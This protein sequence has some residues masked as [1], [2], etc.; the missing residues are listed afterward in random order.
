M[1]ATIAIARVVVLEA[2]RGRVVWLLAA[3]LASAV[4]LAEFMAQVA[5]T[6]SREVARGVL[7]A[8]LRLALVFVVALFVASSMA[9][10]ISDKGMD[11]VLA[12]ALPRSTYL[13]GRLLGYA[14]VS[15]AAA[16][17]AGVLGVLYTTPVVGAIWGAT[18]AG[19]L[20]IVAAATLLAMLTFS[21]MPLGLAVVAGFYLLARAMDAI[22]LVGSNPLA[23]S[24]ASH[25]F[26][27]AVV[28]VVAFVL[29]D[30]G[31]FARADWLIA[32]SASVADLGAALVQTLIYLLLL[33]GA[34]LFDLERKV[35]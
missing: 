10:D 21:H 35:L 2:L 34:A 23:G 4:L 32:A 17:A 9:R 28:E 15:G 25:D 31:T 8:W 26:I 30:L 12:R 13:F 16:A 19:E 22:V 18:L 3:V 29:P 6:E 20:L 1:S 5:I 7:G 24:G 11:L 27:N 33:A 14:A